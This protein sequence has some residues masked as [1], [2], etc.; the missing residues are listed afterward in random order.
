MYYSLRKRDACYKIVIDFIIIIIAV[1][2]ITK[3][4]KVRVK[5]VSHGRK[6]G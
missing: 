5:N 6:I 1:Q 4:K 3:E 2:D